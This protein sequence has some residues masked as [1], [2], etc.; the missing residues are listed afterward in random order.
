MTDAGWHRRKAKKRPQSRKAGGQAQAGGGSLTSVSPRMLTPS[1]IASCSSCTSSGGD[2]AGWLTD[3]C[4]RNVD[5]IRRRQ[6][7]PAVTTKIRRDREINE[8]VSKGRGRR[9]QWDRRA[10]RAQQN[11][12][13]ASRSRTWPTSLLDITCRTA[14]G[15]RSQPPYTRHG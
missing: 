12:R 1:G 11:P 7:R 9:R 15:A 3:D 13:H 8:Y 14:A 6:F 5:R 4:R 10:E 2:D